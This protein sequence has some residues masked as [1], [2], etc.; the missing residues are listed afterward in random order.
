MFDTLNEM[1]MGDKIYE[2]AQDLFQGHINYIDYHYDVDDST[3]EP[4]ERWYDGIYEEFHQA[5]YDAM[6]KFLGGCPLCDDDRSEKPW[7]YGK[8]FD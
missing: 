6:V 8:H 1:D 7:D 4:H 5:V 3:L 2:F